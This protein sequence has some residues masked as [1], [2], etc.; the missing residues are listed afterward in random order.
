LGL[1]APNRRGREACP[2]PDPIHLIVVKTLFHP[3]CCIAQW[4]VEWSP[5]IV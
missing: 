5:W 1:A 3:V 4:P 2:F